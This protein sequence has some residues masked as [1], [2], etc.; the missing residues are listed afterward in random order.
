M[1]KLNSK[2]ASFIAIPV[3]GLL[4]GIMIFQLFFSSSSRVVLKD[5]ASI[6]RIMLHNVK[7][8]HLCHCFPPM[9]AN[10]PGFQIS[11]I[12]SSSAS[13]RWV[14]DVAASYQVNYGTSSSKNTFF[15]TSKGTATYKDYTVTVTGLKPSTQYYASPHSQASGR[16]DFKDWLMSTDSKKAWTFTTL[17]AV[18]ILPENNIPLST[19]M[20]IS[21]VK[22]SKI[23]AA[24]ASLRW[25]TTIPSTSQV[26]YGATEKYGLKSGVN[27]EIS[28]DHY[29]QIFDL[30]P[31][32]TYHY[33]VVSKT[34]D[35]KAPSYSPDYTFTTESFEKKIA[36]K[37]NY[38]VEPNPCV[39]KVE[40]NY[41]LYQ[42]ID[43][44][45]IDIIT[46]S[47]KKVATLEAPGSSLNTGW[48]RISW[49]VKDPSGA[50]L[51]NGLYVYK[52]RFK[53][54]NTE[55][56]FKSAQLSVRR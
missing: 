37:E 55:E 9:I 50:P 5:Q 10:N 31:G 23:M 41:Y 51:I 49:D 3:V 28:K 17:P 48:N 21:D 32:T 8:H 38:F 14:C 47:G 45:T 12:T 22:A 7:G 13:F 56:V 44:L 15:P 6:D 24:E 46:L 11:N 4:G 53:K 27:T 20:S 33:R 35:D 52:M 1:E 18:G 43:N 34:S 40:F 25:K 39:N 29:I 54:G 16:T 19:I 42:Q 36:E 2:K 30:K 26:E